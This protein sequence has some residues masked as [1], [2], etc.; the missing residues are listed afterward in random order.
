MK[1]WTLIVLL[2]LLPVVFGVPQFTAGL[3]RSTAPHVQETNNPSVY[4]AKKIVYVVEGNVS[5]TQEELRRMVKATEESNGPVE[6]NNY[7]VERHGNL[8]YIRPTKAPRVVEEN[9]PRG[10]LAV[11][12]HLGMEV[13][14]EALKRAGKVVIRVKKGTMVELKMVLRKGSVM[15][16]KHLLFDKERNL[17][18]VNIVLFTE[19]NGLYLVEENLP[20][21]EGN[22]ELN[23]HGSYLILNFDP[24]IAWVVKLEANKVESVHYTVRTTVPP[25]VEPAVTR[26]A[27]CDVDVK[28]LDIEETK[29]GIG[30]KFQVLLSGIPVYT[31]KIQLNGSYTFVR[32]GMYYVFESNGPRLVLDGKVGECSFHKEITAPT[33]D[34]TL[35]IAVAFIVLAV[36]AYFLVR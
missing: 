35:I 25:E 23:L 32:N 19:R 20:K 1:R 9:I 34:Y 15:V 27:S 24:V 33:N 8:L 7:T 16:G 12:R 5:L 30:G 26:L 17:A 22:I 14:K 10:I 18:E 36:A 28:F 13:N 11:A 6:V 31:P 29:N 4:Q 3:N 2:L 21:G